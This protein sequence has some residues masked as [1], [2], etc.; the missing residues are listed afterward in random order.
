LTFIAA[1]A[2]FALIAWQTVSRHD[3][4]GAL[5]VAAWLGIA[6]FVHPSLRTA[7]A[8]GAWTGLFGAAFTWLLAPDVKSTPFDGTC[9]RAVIG[10]PY[11]ILLWP[12]VGLSTTL[13]ASWLLS[14]LRRR[15]SALAAAFITLV[16]VGPVGGALAFGEGL[17]VS[18]LGA[19][20]Y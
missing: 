20:R 19:C 5:S 15:G 11:S 13:A 4:G 16:L 7:A 1:T 17:V 2:A 9:L 18:T 14:V 12:L 3:G 10:S 8:I 6:W